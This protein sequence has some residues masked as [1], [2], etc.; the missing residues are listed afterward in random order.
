MS[1][2][3]TREMIASNTPTAPRSAEPGVIGRFMQRAARQWRDRRMIAQLQS[4]EDW[5]LR[6]I[7]IE[8][9]EIPAIVAQL[10]DQEVRMTPVSKADQQ[11]SVMQHAYQKAA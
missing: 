9:G 7:G 10:N 3:I 4:M 1:V 8:R 2:F 11:S 6:D 5:M